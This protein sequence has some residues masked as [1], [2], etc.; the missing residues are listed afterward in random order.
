M[1]LLEQLTTN[2]DY[3]GGLLN[4][5]HADL[6]DAANHRY[7]GLSMD[8]YSDL[9]DVRPGDLIKLRH[10]IG[11]AAFRLEVL[12]RLAGKDELEP[13]QKTT[14]LKELQYG[15]TF[16]KRIP[17]LA[18]LRRLLADAELAQETPLD[19]IR[20]LGR[21]A[22]FWQLSYPDSKRQPI[23][24]PDALFV[25]AFGRDS[26]R[27]RELPLLRQLSDETESDR[28][29]FMKLAEDQFEPGPSND[30]L[31]ENTRRLVTSDHVEAALQWEVAYALWRS[32]PEWY[33]EYEAALH[34]LW[35]RPDLRS[36]RTY[37][38][39]EDSVKISDQRQLIGLY[40]LAHPA[41]YARAVPIIRKLGHHVTAV[42]PMPA[43]PFDPH[44][45]QAQVRDPAQWI[46]R[47]LPTRIHHLLPTK[48]KV[49]F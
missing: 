23:I 42:Q 19:R 25:Q 43:I 1:S 13:D 4:I 9:P 11:G 10:D 12:S 16:D 20:V 30:A 2:A 36:Y 22:A 32:D 8:E 39:K 27:D 31:A 18:Y 40:E 28:D 46:L 5:P 33:T 34:V 35:P 17:S 6:L 49:S 41:M 21:Y 15:D 26:L 29:V 24:T 47:E 48:R 7:N 44:S 45:T 14:A 3:H 37:Q 38:V